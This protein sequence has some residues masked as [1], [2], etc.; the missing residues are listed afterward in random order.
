MAGPHILVRL[1]ERIPRAVRLG[2]T[3]VDALLAHHRDH[4]ELSPSGRPGV[5]R[6]TARG[7]VGVIPLPSRRLALRPKLPAANV[8]HLLDP[9]G[10]PPA[11]AD[12][13]APVDAAGFLD[14]LAGRLA[15]LMAGRAAAGLHRDYAE[16]AAA[17]PYLRGRLDVPALA[18][19]GPP[20]HDRLHCRYEEFTPDVPCNRLPRAVANCLLDRPDVGA[21]VKAA[22][23][24]ALAGWADVAPAPLT[25]DLCAAEVPARRA[26]GYGPLLDLCRLLAAGLRSGE[27]TGSRA[28]PAFL[29]DLERVFERYVTAGVGRTLGEPFAAQ[30]LLLASPPQP[31]QPDFR[32]RP[33]VLLG[34][35]GRPR[36]VLDVKWKRLSRQALP[37]DD[38]YQV[39]AYA[40]TLDA[41]RAVLVYPGR[42]DRRWHYPTAR[43]PGL[44]VVTL[45][46]VGPAERCERSLRRLGRWL[47]RPPA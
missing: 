30:P 42:R 39:L 37:T 23:R 14:V 12:R 11:V 24:E 18:R 25:P 40:A 5:Y 6:L 19:A 38:V 43:G 13:S 20:R 21:P 45:R 35:A 16:H 17:T 28:G 27:E 33:D 34:P 15:A 41:P 32:V 36:L 22:L 3:D 7:F 8:Y 29:I 44:E 9:F 31:G 46:V 26:D 2:R 10:P 1:T 4:V 47:R